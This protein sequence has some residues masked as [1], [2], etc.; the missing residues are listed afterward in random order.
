MTEKQL[1]SPTTKDFQNVFAFLMSQ[2]IPFTFHPSKRLDENVMNALRFVGY[3]YTVSK[4]ALSA[5]GSS[6]T[7]P[8]LLGVL[9]WLMGRAIHGEASY[10]RSEEVSASKQEEVQ[11]IIQGHTKNGYQTFLKGEEQISDQ[12]ATITN[13]FEDRSAKMCEEIKE[14]TK[15][16]EQRQQKLGELR[17]KTSP[18]EEILGHRRELESN[19][20]K[21]NMLIPS[22]VD[23]RK[24]VQDTVEK[25][26]GDVERLTELL[27]ELSM[28]KKRDIEVIDSQR[29]KSI[30]ASEIAE[31]R[32]NL[33]KSIQMANEEKILIDEGCTQAHE[34]LKR[35]Q[36]EA[37]ILMK[38]SRQFIEQLGVDA[39]RREFVVRANLNSEA[40]E[41]F[42]N[43]DSVIES[44][45]KFIEK[46]DDENRK[47]EE[48]IIKH[49]WESDVLEDKAKSMQ[50]EMESTR[51]RLGKYEREFEK[52]RKEMDVMRENRSD[53]V[54]SRKRE[55][56]RRRMMV[57]SILDRASEE[58]E[59][60]KKGK[61][62]A[63]AAM[64]KGRIEAAA[65]MREEAE[66]IRERK[67]EMVR[68]LAILESI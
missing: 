66:K 16:F 11:Q 38:S 47:I 41:M 45:Q 3:P 18:L 24:S 17:S 58:V 14:M 7:W 25:M 6:H 50:Q 64:D 30:S 40:S 67:A 37:E 33:R 2:S 55:G 46:L 28:E 39:G 34:M 5:V 4:S 15:S 51:G 21:F 48:S 44:L 59:A 63:E 27:K 13:L 12:D 26:N 1:K 52:E 22:M 65:M 23:H 19:V 29:S 42:P 8:A 57:N 56:E 43:L 54:I 61:E 60:A 53:R 68:S 36:A 32:A 62:V 20:A 9:S 31:K 49:E 10:T 35:V